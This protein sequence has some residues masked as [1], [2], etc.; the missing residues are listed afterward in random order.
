VLFSEPEVA[1]PKH[2]PVQSTTLI[3][4]PFI[5]ESTLNFCIIFLRCE[6][7]PSDS[8]DIMNAQPLADQYEGPL[9]VPDPEAKETP[10]LAMLLARL[11][12]F[13]RY[14]DSSTIK[15]TQLGAK[16][17]MRKKIECVMAIQ[18]PKR[19]K[20]S[21]SADRGN[22]SKKSLKHPGQLQILGTWFAVAMES[23]TAPSLNNTDT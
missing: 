5:G 3:G 15:I 16:R 22:S 10:G 14:G 19:C 7:L 23:D 13:K 9:P 11:V 12:S 8:P 4:G 6:C 17:C 21:H 20:L 1:K 18:S 2:H